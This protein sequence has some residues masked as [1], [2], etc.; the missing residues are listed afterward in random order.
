MKRCFQFV[1]LFLSLMG[2]LI[3]S[4]C[5]PVEQAAGGVRQLENE[6]APPISAGATDTLS[7]IPSTS[8]SVTISPTQ[9]PL[10][11]EPAKLNFDLATAETN[12]ANLPVGFT[13][14]GYPTIGNPNAR[15]V[16]EEFS[17]YQCPFCARFYAQTLPS[18]LA[19]QVKS[20]QVV[21]VFRDFPLESIHP[22]A[23]PA[24]L[25]ARCVGE[26]GAI[27]YWEMHDL[28]F[29]N[30]SSWSNGD[31]Q[32]IFQQYARQVGVD[33]TLF[34]DCVSNQKYAD[35]IQTDIDAGTERGVGSTPTFF[36]NN[37]PLVG[38]MPLDIF[39]QAIAYVEAGQPVANAIP[40]PVPTQVPVAPTPAT[41]SADYAFALHIWDA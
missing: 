17:D 5:G 33:E 21:I 32:T 9:A 2:L 41:I 11:P 6:D 4:A 34:N 12:S 29:E 35:L 18:L 13:I 8:E 16:I 14:E 28:L 37:Q 40:T 30:L 10:L 39:N 31:H 20:G 24:A 22:L 15:I 23:Q 27:A 7:T 25:A 1:G 26:Q 19:N 38:A 3:I 36:I